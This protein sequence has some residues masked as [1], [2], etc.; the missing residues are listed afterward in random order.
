GNV[1]SP[2]F[3]F[4]LAVQKG[5]TPAGDPALRRATPESIRSLTLE[6]VRRYHDAVV[7][8]DQTTIVIMGRIDP[9]AARALI[10]KHFGAWKAVGPRPRLDYLPVPASAASEVFVAD[11]VRQQDEVIIAETLPLTYDDP[12]HYALRLGNGFLGG[13]SFASPLYRELRVTRGLVYSVGASMGFGRTRSQ[14]YVTFGASPSNVTQAR[15]IAIKVVQGMA[16]RP[17]TERELHLAKAQ[18]LRDI[19]LGN[20]SASDIAQGWL[21]YSEEN[22]SLNRLF[23]IARAYEGLSAD[24]VQAAFRKYIDTGRL[25]TFTL[26]KAVTQ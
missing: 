26:G 3:Q 16:E 1:R 14:F 17:M 2:V 13:D 7:R 15:Q 9:A 25:S 23:E 18:G 19:E 12:D 11:P 21:A 10:E 22:L 8:P 6:D 5:L 20:Q 24:Q 4:N